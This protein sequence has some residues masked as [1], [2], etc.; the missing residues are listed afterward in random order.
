MEK[1]IQPFYEVI[2]SISKLYKTTLKEQ[3]K[4]RGKKLPHNLPTAKIFE[5]ACMKDYNVS[6]NYVYNGTT[7]ICHM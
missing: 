4:C 3:R 6:I 2:D 1:R 7:S 5:R